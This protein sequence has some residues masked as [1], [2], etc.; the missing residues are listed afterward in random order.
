MT[1]DFETEHLPQLGEALSREHGKT[2]RHNLQLDVAYYQ[3]LF[4]DPE[5][6]DA[7]K[8]QIITALW[9]IIVAFVELGFGVHAA[10]QACGKVGT[11]QDQSSHADA[12]SLD[13][14]GIG[15]FDRREDAPEP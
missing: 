9:S 13:W 6:S 5:L 2:V 3:D 8:E 1:Q 12:D 7:E 14:E 15:K 10:Q 11:K 4:D